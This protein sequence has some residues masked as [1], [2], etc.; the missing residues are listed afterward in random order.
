MFCC[1]FKA[2]KA[3]EG[4]N[5]AAG[6]LLSVGLDV[7]DNARWLGSL[8]HYFMDFLCG[9]RAMMVTGRGTFWI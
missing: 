3:V 5:S 8:N 7:P 6:L 4:Q 1:R 2:F 9:E